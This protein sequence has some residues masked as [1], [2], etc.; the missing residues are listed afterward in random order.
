LDK[1]KL[2]TQLPKPLSRPYLL[3]WAEVVVAVVVLEVVEVVEVG[4]LEV[5]EVEE[6]VEVR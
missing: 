2:K 4:L 3:H 1:L 5:V 6:L